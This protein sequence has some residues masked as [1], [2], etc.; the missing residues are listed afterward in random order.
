MMFA[1]SF[2]NPAIQLG[3]R[4]AHRTDM[5][6][7]VREFRYAFRTFVRG[8]FVTVLGVLA[9]AL[10]IGVTSAV[11]SIFNSVILQPLAYPDPDELVVVFDTQ[12]ALATAP[13]SFPKYHDWKDRNHVFAAIGGST[14][15]PF[16]L[17][18]LGDPERVAGIAT[19]ASLI[20]VLRVQPVLGRWYSDRED[21]P[22]GPKVVVLSY[23][24]WN[25]HFNRDRRVVGRRLTLNGEPYEVIGVMPQAFNH[26][27]GDVFVPLQQKLDPATRGSHFLATLA[28]LK[29]GVSVERAANEMR[30]LGQTLAKEFGHNHGIDVRSYYEVIVGN[31]RAPLRVLLGAVFL[32]L[33]IAC[34]NVA[35]LLLASGLARRRELAIRLALGAGWRDLARQLTS[36]AVVLALVGGAIGVLLA[37]WAIRLFVTLAGTS[38]PRASTVTIDGSVLAFTAALS[39]LVGLICGVWPLIR[40]RTREIAGAVRERDTRTGSGGGGSFG[41]GLVIAEI[42]IAFALLVGAGLLIKNLML[43]ERRD[44]GIQTERIVAFDVAPSGPRYQDRA[45]IVAFYRDLLERLQ[46]VGGVESLGA[47]SGLPMYRFG[48]NGEVS[49]PGGTP[50][51]A[52][53]APLV[54][55]RRIG[56]DYFKTLGIPLLRGRLFDARD[57]DG[58][59][60]VVVIN[61]AM[62]EKFFPS[63]DPIGKRIAPGGGTNYLE[64][65]G[66]VGD[67]RS[68]GLVAK[69]PYELYRTIAQQ[70]AGGLTIVLRTSTDEPAAVVSAARRIVASIDPLLPITSVQT[71]EQVVSASVGQPRLLSALT[72]LFGTLAGLLAMVGVYGVTSYNVRRQRRE[73]GIRLA[74][75]ADP[76]AVQ[77]L[78]VRRGTIVALTGVAIGSIGA[79]LLTGTLRAMLNDVQP[80]DPTVFA[81]N[82]AL[83]FVVSILACY[84]PARAAGKVDPMV[85]LREN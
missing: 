85:V 24:F 48:M 6:R 45:Q 38:L 30:A 19:T 42:A 28:R 21:Q 71:M 81:L 77:K 23:G 33:L 3:P 78:V 29:K 70:P 75:G 56:G 31:V 46:S 10:G 68:F 41:N 50:W 73:F 4:I 84:L 79:F 82:A 5:P 20:D 17:T 43:L 1:G 34:A 60:A 9:F 16:S 8:R 25:R 65:I 72:A 52:S 64:V 27:N 59:A 32:V 26:R 11:F 57:R 47:T 18:G 80:T 54:E 15:S 51:G 76:V 63:Q 66:V 53:E 13:A 55:F 39:L 67:V 7:I 44:A 35:N 61:H 40:L 83:V 22:G 58:S 69:S 36:E 14:P 2:A 62:A 49:L 37:S 12:P 74:L